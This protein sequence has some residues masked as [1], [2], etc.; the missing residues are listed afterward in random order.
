MTWNDYG[1]SHY[2]GPIVDSGIPSGGNDAGSTDAHPYVDGYPHSAWLGTLPYQIAAYKNAYNAANPAPSVQAGGEKIV[3]WYRTS[4]ASAGTTD[5]VGNDC[6]SPVNSGGYQTCYTP[7][8]VLEDGIFAI[9]LASTPGSASITIGEGQP[10]V[11][12][13]IVPGINFVSRS[14]SGETGN[15][16]VSMG[17]IVGEGVEI[18]AEPTSGMANF[19]AWV[20]CAGACTYHG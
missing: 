16:T 3:Y 15:V 12:D 20:G 4:P 19:N 13:S 18:S 2:I 1:E 5:A 14:F 9:V 7:A 8:E 17:D 11:F 10:T 6:P